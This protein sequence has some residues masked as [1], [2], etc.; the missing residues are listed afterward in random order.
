MSEEYIY[1]Y[2]ENA[3]TNIHTHILYM[4][5]EKG[6]FSNLVSYNFRESERTCM[7]KDAH[8]ESTYRMNT[9]FRPRSQREPPSFFFHLFFF[10]RHYCLLL[11]LTL[12]AVV[13]A[14]NFLC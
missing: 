10:L 1:T 6:K 11:L 8:V 9:P 5:E 13:V 3:H 4:R 12:V 7:G 14:V 2:I